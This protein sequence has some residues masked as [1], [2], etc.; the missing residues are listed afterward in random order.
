MVYN[1]HS[2]SHIILLVC[3]TSRRDPRTHALKFQTE[4]CHSP[5]PSIPHSAFPQI[6]ELIN[7]GVG[8]SVFVLFL[9]RVD[10]T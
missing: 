10:E 7:Q 4:R 6:P 8:M 5:H 3:Y 9:T 1:K 2:G